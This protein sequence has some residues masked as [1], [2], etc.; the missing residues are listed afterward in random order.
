MPVL[1]DSGFN[2]VDVRDVVAGA[3]EAEKRAPTGAKYLLS[4]HWASL[5][6]LA[7]MIE[8]VTGT[9]CPSLTCPMWIADIGAPF[10]TTFSAVI[11][12]TT[13]LYQSISHGF[14][15]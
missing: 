5:R 10:A 1:L 12:E 8:E 4:G 15:W 3:M 9:G 7:V 2:W 14:A 13:A 11:K 6:D